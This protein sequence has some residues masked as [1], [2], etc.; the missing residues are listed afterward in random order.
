MM[1]NHITV[2]IVSVCLAGW[3]EQIV[4]AFRQT[5]KPH[6]PSGVIM[7]NQPVLITR[8]PSSAVFHGSPSSTSSIHL[9]ISPSRILQ[10]VFVIFAGTN[11]WFCC[12]NSDILYVDFQL[13]YPN[14][15][16]NTL[17]RGKKLLTCGFTEPFYEVKVRWLVT[18]ASPLFFCFMW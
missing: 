9:L 4:D 5:D 11:A 13:L 10:C 6:I 1:W 18:I 8:Q 7:F 17:L 3:V 2:V 15:P 14:L 12:S 16:G